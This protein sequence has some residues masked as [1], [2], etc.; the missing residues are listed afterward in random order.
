MFKVAGKQLKMSSE[1]G[2]AENSRKVVCE[3]L[4]FFG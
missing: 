4:T 2:E 1:V 3:L